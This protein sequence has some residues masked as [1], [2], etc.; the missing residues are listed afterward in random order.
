M[1]DRFI[2]SWIRYIKAAGKLH[3]SLTKQIQKCF[4]HYLATYQLSSLKKK[5]GRITQEK[6]DYCGV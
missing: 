4:K 5:E 6:N 2:F 1:S 3:D